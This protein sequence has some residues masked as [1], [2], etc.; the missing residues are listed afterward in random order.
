MVRRSGHPGEFRGLASGG[1]TKVFSLAA[2]VKFRLPA[3]SSEGIA[4]WDVLCPVPV[5]EGISLKGLVMKLFSAVL[6]ATISAAPALAGTTLLTADPHNGTTTVFTNTG[7]TYASGSST[8]DGFSVTGTGTYASGNVTYGLN[9]NGTWNHFSWVGTDDATA[10]ITFN[11]GGSYNEVGAFLNYCPGCG[12]T[13]STITA[14]A[15][16][17]STILASYDLVTLAP[18]LTAGAVERRRLP[19]YQQHLRRYQLPETDRQLRGSALA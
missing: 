17:G 5:L 7:L 1:I 18:I 16:D 19:G 10:S 2:K 14:L 3:T 4:G 15:A 11:L 9:T 8:L 6:L 13:D 12:G